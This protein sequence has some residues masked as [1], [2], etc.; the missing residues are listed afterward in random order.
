[1]KKSVDSA[2]INPKNEKNN[3]KIKAE[4]DKAIIINNSGMAMIL[5]MAE[6][7]E[8]ILKKFTVNGRSPSQTAKEAVNNVKI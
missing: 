4:T 8:I 3:W 2:N 7:G 6:M 5:T 1:M